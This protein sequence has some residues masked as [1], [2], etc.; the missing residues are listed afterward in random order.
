M[1]V[2]RPRLKIVRRL[3]VQLPGLTRKDAGA[4]P[5]P[6]GQHGQSTGR[7]RKVSAFR[8]RLEEKQKI[9]FHYGIGERQL[10]RYVERAGS[11]SGIKS[12]NLFSMVERR[13]DN[14]VFRLGFAPT[15]PA[16]RQLV[17][18]GHVRVDGAKVDRPS[19]GVSIGETITLSTKAR[20]RPSIEE[21]IGQGPLVKLPSYLAHDPSDA[22]AGRI[23]ATPI[24]SDVPFQ[25][26]DSAVVE[27]YSR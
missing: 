13:L 3:G 12:H 16:A 8:R 11:M 10:R 18:H 22:G 17:S 15:I 14:V 1:S 6:P 5:Y 23:I 25:V 24:R 20:A 2:H 4:R 19:Y 26:E 9:R 7:R 21:A 27:F